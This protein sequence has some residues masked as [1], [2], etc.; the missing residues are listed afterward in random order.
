M[1]GLIKLTF[2][3]L[4]S[5]VIAL[6]MFS[7]KDNDDEENVISGLRYK[8]KQDE[9]QPVLS[10]SLTV[11]IRFNIKRLGS[12]RNFA[13]IFQIGNEKFT[14]FSLVA[15]YP[16]S[17]IVL[18]NSNHEEESSIGRILYDPKRK[19]YPMWKLYIWHHICMSYSKKNSHISFV[20][21]RKTFL[22][23]TYS[24]K[25]VILSFLPYRNQSSIWPCTLVFF[26]H[27]NIIYKSIRN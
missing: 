19:G 24:V 25:N 18:G 3:I 2:L 9:K 8:S 12:W 10:N 21:V 16:E 17:W 11:C 5:N 26:K 4:L 15:Q 14:F 20:Q 1:K 23:Y 13:L 22:V 27:I 6:K 7:S